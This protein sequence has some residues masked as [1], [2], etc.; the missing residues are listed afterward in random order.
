M[1]SMPITNLSMML[2][3]G[4]IINI[5]PNLGG[6]KYITI[7]G[8][9]CGPVILEGAEPFAVRNMLNLMFPE[10]VSANVPKPESAK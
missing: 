9:K 4:T 10:W 6:A 5:M 1:A 2:P 7:E 3:N 8:L